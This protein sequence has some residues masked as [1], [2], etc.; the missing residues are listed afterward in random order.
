MHERRT[1]ERRTEHFSVAVA[2]EAPCQLD[3]Q[4]L[5]LSRTGVLLEAKGKIPI[6]L[7]IKGQR[8]QGVLVRASQKPGG[9]LMSYAIQ[10]TH[11]L[12][13]S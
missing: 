6:T 2:I 9:G 1:A 7:T 3:G 8:Y 10:L 11:N 13:L 5:N 12:L 4:T